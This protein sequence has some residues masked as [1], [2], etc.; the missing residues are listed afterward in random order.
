[1]AFLSSAEYQAKF[2]DPASFVRSLYRTL[3]F[4]GASDAEVA[5][6]VNALDAGASRACVV[7]SVLHGLEASL[8]AV[9]TVHAFLR[10]EADP[11]GREGFADL[12]RQP[13]GKVIDVMLA[14]L[15][16]DEYRG[17]FSA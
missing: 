15:A 7:R 8:R 12:L 3:L 13:D 1:V 2:P 4:R 11:A 9:D 16:S 17:R 6:W 14:V 10:R 5:G